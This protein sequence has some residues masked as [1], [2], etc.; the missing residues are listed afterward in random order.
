MGTDAPPD[1]GQD[2]EI[3]ENKAVTVLFF[4]AAREAVGTA[5]AVLPAAG[6]TVAQLLLGLGST[7]GDQLKTVLPSCSVWVNGAPAPTGSVLRGGDEV[8]LMPP[9]SGG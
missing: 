1:A 6:K 4:A 2:E 3:D 9:V 8:A 5:R 7:Y